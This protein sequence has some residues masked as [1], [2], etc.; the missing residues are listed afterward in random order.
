V[1]G[2]ASSRW[3]RPPTR[4]RSCSCPSRATPCRP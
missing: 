4:P 2:R 3:R 1:W